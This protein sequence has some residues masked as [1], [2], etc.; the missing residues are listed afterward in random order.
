MTFTAGVI[1]LVIFIAALAVA[2]RIVIE[3]TEGGEES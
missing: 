3:L 2:D 1:I